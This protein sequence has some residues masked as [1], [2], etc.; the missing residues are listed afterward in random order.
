VDIVLSAEQKTLLQIIE[1]TKE[2]IFITGKAGTG[3]SV[4]LSHFREQTAKRVAVTAYTGIAALNVKGQTI[5]SLFKLGMGLQEPESLKANTR[6]RLDMLLR[7]I[8]TLVIDEISMVRADIMDAID[9][10][11]RTAR[12]NDIAFGGVQIVMFGDVFQL[13]PVVETDLFQYFEDIYGGHFFFH[14]KVWK[15]AEFK[16]FELS[17]IFRQK[18]PAFRDILNAVRNGT[19]TDAQ[20]EQLNSRHGGALPEDG[21]VTLAPTNELVARINQENLSRLPGRV[22]EYKATITGG[23]KRGTFPTEEYLQLKVGAQIVL[24]KN[25]KDGRW[26][27]G[28]VGKVESLHEDHI[29]I[30]VNDQVSRLE[31]ESWEEIIYEYDAAKGKVEATIGSSFT[32][33]PLKLAWAL[34]VHKSQ[35]QTYERVL[36]DLSTGMFAAGQLYVALSRCTSMEG[37]WLKRPV[38]REYVIVNPKVV[39]FMSRCETIVVEEESVISTA[40]EEQLETVEPVREEQPG[41]VVVQ[42]V[43]EAVALVKEAQA[44]AETLREENSSESLAI[45]DQALEPAALP[46]EVRSI[47]QS[48]VIVASASMEIDSETVSLFNSETAEEAA[49]VIVEE[50]APVCDQVSLIEGRVARIA[51]IEVLCPACA[52]ICVDPRTGSTYITPDLVG[53]SIACSRC[54]KSCIVPLNAFSLLGEVIARE[55]PVQLVSNAKVEKQGRRK[56]ERKSNAG[57]KPQGREP[58]QPLQLSLDTRVIKTLK[59]WRVNASALYIELLGQYMPFLEK[60]REVVGE[61]YGEESEEDDE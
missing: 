60:Y 31:R 27:N 47:E 11:F 56:K 24:L 2:N 21:T 57:A 35:G 44:V 55:K 3:K 40:A 30:R 20:I 28:T 4:L 29:D 19:A 7:R 39:E 23:M 12:K 33:Y 53:H 41:E 52:E 14:A 1:E 50:I 42:T 6:T 9:A 17:Q 38:K 61:D 51:A 34:T 10:R 13:P 46:D 36:L 25:D 43:A 26:V 54:E 5:H 45:I 8:D 18:D 37:L 15:K 48:L 16:V 22:K 59:V 49:T 58:K 32:Q